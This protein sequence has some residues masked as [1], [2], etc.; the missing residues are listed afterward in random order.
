[1]D[2]LT[3]GRGSIRASHNS[4]Q[5]TSLGYGGYFLVLIWR[6]SP[7]HFRCFPIFPVILLNTIADWHGTAMSA[8][9]IVGYCGD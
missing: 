4:N 7:V 2:V 8:F 3:S 5:R 9:T 1:M 6:M